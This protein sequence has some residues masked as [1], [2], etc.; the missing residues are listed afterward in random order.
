MREWRKNSLRDFLRR[1]LL[2][3]ESPHRTSL[4]FGVG[5]LIGFSPFWGLH[6]VL[7][8]A[9]SIVARLNRV[10]V[11]IG[12]WTNTPWTMAPA[13]SVGTA[14]GLLMLGMNIEFPD[15]PQGSFVS[16]EF[17]QGTWT[18]F[19]YLLWPFFVGNMGL[20]MGAG[21]LGYFV[22]K[23]ILSRNRPRMESALN[24]ELESSRTPDIKNQ[25]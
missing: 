23:T 4:A 2:L 16:S 24:I 9:V 20:A 15:L 18:E 12:V 11:L 25:S 6:T 21:G 8:L 5:V 13:A 3:D 14:L 1:L 7:G 10:A 17:W 19:S 22:M